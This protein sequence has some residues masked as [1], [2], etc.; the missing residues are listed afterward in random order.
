MNQREPSSRGMHLRSLHTISCYNG[1]KQSQD[2]FSATPPNGNPNSKA[3]VSKID[4]VKSRNGKVAHDFIIIPLGKTT[5]PILHVHMYIYSIY[6]KDSNTNNM[7]DNS[8]AIKIRYFI[9]FQLYNMILVQCIYEYLSHVRWLNP[10]LGSVPP[11]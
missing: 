3:H 4:T 2:G 5:D 8:E 1:C 11:C 6:I 10:C 9:I 7:N